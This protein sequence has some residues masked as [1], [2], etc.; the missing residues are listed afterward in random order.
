VEQ[1]T[2]DICVTSE[3]SMLRL[4]FECF[5]SIS[6]KSAIVAVG[7]LREGTV[8]RNVHCVDDLKE[9][10]SCDWYAPIR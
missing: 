10:K 5:Q 8:C 1:D 7:F 6:I 2:D 4:Q 3:S 9:V